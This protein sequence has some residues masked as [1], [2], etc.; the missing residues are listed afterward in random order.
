MERRIGQE[1]MYRNRCF[2][3]CFCLRNHQ[4]K[5]ELQFNGGMYQ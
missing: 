5:R 1:L 3:F 2:V 4:R